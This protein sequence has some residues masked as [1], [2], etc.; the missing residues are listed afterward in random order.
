MAAIA[1]RRLGCCL[2]AGAAFLGSAGGASAA[3]CPNEPLRVGDSAALAEC[4]A[5][6]LVTPEI[7]ANTFKPEIGTAGGLRG[8]FDTWSSSP[9]GETVIFQQ[10]GAV[11][12][13]GSTGFQEQYESKRTDQGWITQSQ[14][15]STL[16]AGRPAPIMGGSTPDHGLTFWSQRENQT[17]S[18]ENG[19]WL[20]AESHPISPIGVGSLGADLNAEGL[21]MTEGGSHVIFENQHWSNSS[22][23]VS[24]LSAAPAVQLEPQAPPS[25]I[26]AI[27]DRSLGEGTTRVVSLLPGGLTPAGNARYLGASTDGEAVVFE[28]NGTIYVRRND[29]TTAIVA[30]PVAGTVLL[31]EPTNPPANADANSSR[32]WLRNG[33]PIPGATEPRYTVQPADEGAAIQCQVTEPGGATSTSSPP[34][35]I[36]SGSASDPPQPARALVAPSPESPEIGDVETCDEGTWV[37]SPNLRFQW[38]ANSEKIVGANS[39]SYELQA[40]D[41]PSNIQCSV[42]ATNAAGSVVVFSPSIP[43]APA[44]AGVHRA[45][46]VEVHGLV[47]SSDSGQQSLASIA[48]VSS[49][50]GKVFFA[51]SFGGSE[52]GRAMH[53][54]YD[55]FEVYE[56]G[57]GTLRRIADEGAIWPVQ[58]SEDGSHA[59]FISTAVLAS[60]DD[61]LGEPAVSGEDNLYV[62]TSSGVQFITTVLPADVIGPGGSAG[63]SMGLGQLTVTE[64]PAAIPSEAKGPALD[65]SRITPN[66]QVLVFQSKGDLTPGYES[67]EHSEIFRYDAS[68]GDLVCV[69]CNPSGAV[70]SNDSELETIGANVGEDKW[71]RMVTNSF[72]HVANVTPDGNTIVFETRE[73]LVK[74]DEDGFYDVY[75]WNNGKLS[76][77]SSGTGN[78][79]EFLYG[80]S[81]DASNVF[82][83]SD[84]TLVPQDEDGL[85]RSIYD[86]RIDG[87]FA[88]K[89][90]S[91]CEGESCQGPLAASPS[92]AMP[93][94]SVALSSGNVVPKHHKKK[95]H[96]KKHHKKKHHKKKHHKKKHHR[97]GEKNGGAK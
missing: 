88:P 77:I 4:R 65:T 53:E 87:G 82:F 63:G 11:Q 1:I 84:Q 85:N 60:N 69:S 94:T 39:S 44:P 35:V 17:G 51:R 46:I 19:N 61:A 45:P 92:L 95:H 7:G 93:S 96:K 68:T 9:N 67:G 10:H 72:S 57:T 12:D 34:T 91:A 16:E 86:A 36:E 62:W 26:E 89:S 43:T 18:L 13:E 48:A 23:H 31:C 64:N 3:E 81:R 27:Y 24:G 56:A 15:P 58:V 47:A 21:W 79:A 8:G 80:M 30:R 71:E 5:Y 38:Y 41:V 97:A 75:L 59:Y 33:S 55:T 20:F 22:G 40:A 50:G 78:E 83:V 74:E 29:L 32:E 76:L 90:V 66:G 73:A 52:L 14:G 25:P 49:G 54:G 6:E 70:A 2:L 28:I 42:E 37:G